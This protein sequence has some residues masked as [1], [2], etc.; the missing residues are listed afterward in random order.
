MT[1][2]AAI[3]EHPLATQATG[4]VVGQVLEQVGEAP[5]LAVLFVTPLPT[6]TSKAILI[7]PNELGAV[8]VLVNAIELP[9]AVALNVAVPSLNPC[10]RYPSAVTR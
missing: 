8:S 9:T 5:D 10:T 1:F 2:G 3:S 4:E 6:L 7:S